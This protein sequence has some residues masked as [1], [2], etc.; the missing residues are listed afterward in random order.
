MHRQALDRTV[1]CA[2]TVIS[3][4]APTTK[5][6]LCLRLAVAQSVLQ[7]PCRDRQQDLHHI[8]SLLGSAAGEQIRAL[9]IA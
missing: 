4:A 2:V 1:Q 8:T 9:A 6:R 7:Y 5:P 3:M